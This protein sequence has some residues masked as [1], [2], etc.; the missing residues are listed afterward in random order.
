MGV[1]DYIEYALGSALHS[2]KGHDAKLFTR[3][4][5]AFS[6]FPTPTF[7]LNCPECGPSESSLKEHHT[8]FLDKKKGE[9]R[10]QFPEL[11]WTKPSPDVR[12]YVLVVEDPDIP[13][14]F[15]ALH[16]LYYAIPGD[17]TIFT[18]ADLEVEDAKEKRLKGGVRLGKNL[19]G[20][21]YGGARPPFGHGPHRYFFSLIA[22]NDVVDQSKLS[23]LATKEE[24]AREMEGKVVGWG[25]WIGLY[26]RKW[27]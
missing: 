19:A 5:P 2:V 9:P 11:S 12:E 25:L 23:K 17:K 14:P 4:T 16:G 15:V 27:K 24:L 6:N 3:T 10:D 8:S 18:H 13:L 20:T 22:L 21:V 1:G 26:E 7:T